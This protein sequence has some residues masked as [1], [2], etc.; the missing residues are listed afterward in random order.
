M[1]RSRRDRGYFLALMAGAL[2]H[3]AEPGNAAAAGLEALAVAVETYSLRTVH[4]LKRVCVLLAPW[5][6]QP[7]VHELREAVV[8]QWLLI[9]ST[10]ARM[11]SACHC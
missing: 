7:A 3:A 8:A 6:S 1:S 11:T 4:E 2:A 5:S 10:T 9:Q